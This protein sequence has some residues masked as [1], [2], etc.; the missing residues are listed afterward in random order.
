MVRSED[1]AFFVAI[2]I[3]ERWLKGVVHQS[4]VS[5]LG[6]LCDDALL[7]GGFIEAEAA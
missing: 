7:R 3:V 6:G 2:A 5:F 1:V 4:T